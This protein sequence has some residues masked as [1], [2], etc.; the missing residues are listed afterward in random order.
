MLDFDWPRQILS[1]LMMKPVLALVLGIALLIGCNRQGAPVSQAVNSNAVTTANVP[2]ADKQA[3][4]LLKEAYDSIQQKKAGEAE[5]KLREV[6][7]MKPKLS[8]K[9]RAQVGPA[10]VGLG[11]LDPKRGTT[12]GQLWGE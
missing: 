7:A 10:I 3:E 1:E 6:I 8:P 11:M 2:D 9:V 12:L 5:T 4:A